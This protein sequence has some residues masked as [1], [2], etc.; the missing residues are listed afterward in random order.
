MYFVFQTVIIVSK[1]QMNCQ[2]MQTVVQNVHFLF[3]GYA[4][5]YRLPSRQCQEIKMCDLY[6]F[7]SFSSYG[8]CAKNITSDYWF[9][10]DSLWVFGGTPQ[11]NIR[12]SNS[13]VWTDGNFLCSTS[14]LWAFEWALIV[15]FGGISVR[16]NWILKMWYLKYLKPVMNKINIFETIPRDNTIG[17]TFAK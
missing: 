10:T 7:L 5:F 14:L 13:H 16:K 1:C 12:N 11:N 3:S 9:S 4:K 8:T 15:L 17:I 6:T 2:T